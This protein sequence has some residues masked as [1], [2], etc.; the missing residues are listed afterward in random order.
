MAGRPYV[1]RPRGNL[2]Q[3]AAA[4]NGNGNIL[5]VAGLAS[6]SFQVSGTLTGSIVNFEFTI[7]NTNWLALQVSNV[8]NGVISTTTTAAGGFVAAVAGL[9][10]VRARVSNYTG[11]DAIT[12]GGMGVAVGQGPFSNTQLIHKTLELDGTSG[13]GLINT[14]GTL[15][16]VTGEV[17]VAVIAGYCTES[18][19]S[20]GGGKVYLGVQ[21]QVELFISATLATTID[22]G[23]FWV[24][25]STRE[26][27]GGEA[28]P[29]GCKDTAITSNI[30]CSANVA[31]VTDGTLR[32]DL[33]WMPLSADGNVVAA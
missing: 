24:D 25:D 3:N 14:S 16:T 4:A 2:F 30:I 13:K 29:A 9:S 27:N 19:V 22:T 6:V 17:L 32:F 28:V 33:Y 26:A 12:V 23:M 10:Q 18:L 5:D 1:E 11:S 21:N 31:S 8:A 7:D 20:A 15:F